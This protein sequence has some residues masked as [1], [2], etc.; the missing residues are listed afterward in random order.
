MFEYRGFLGFVVL[1]LD[2]WA[3]I[4]RESRLIFNSIAVKV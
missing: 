1:I 2:L 3:I 4:R